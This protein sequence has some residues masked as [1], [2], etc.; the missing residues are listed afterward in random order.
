MPHLK[1]QST[2]LVSQEY[3]T[4]H[5]QITNNAYLG[6]KLVIYLVWSLFYKKI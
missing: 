2:L 3:Y 6:Q 5:K 1:P 4:T